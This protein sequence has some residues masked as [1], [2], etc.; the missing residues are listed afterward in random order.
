MKKIAT[1]LVVAA[2]LALSASSASAWNVPTS[3]GDLM[4]AGGKVALQTALNKKL[5]DNN[6]AFKKGTANATCDLNK[7]GKELA[8]A[9]TAIREGAN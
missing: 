6:C 2:G 8:A 4:N 1:S 7:I 3:G 9:Y 5:S